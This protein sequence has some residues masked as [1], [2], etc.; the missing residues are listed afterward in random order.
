MNIIGG[1][2]K[3]AAKKIEQ[4]FVTIQNGPL[5][6]LGGGKFQAPELEKLKKEKKKQKRERR[7]KPLVADMKSASKSPR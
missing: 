7:I 3:T 2:A 4:L 6:V 1:L 5:M